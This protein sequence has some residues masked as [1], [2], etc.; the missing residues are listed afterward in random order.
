[1]YKLPYSI[2]PDKREKSGT[3]IYFKGGKKLSLFNN[4]SCCGNNTAGTTQTKTK[5]G[6]CVCELLNQLA[7]ARN[8]GDFCTLAQTMAQPQAF[9]IIVKGSNEP[10]GVSPGQPDE[11]TLLSFDPE[12]CCA[13]FA[14]VPQGMQ[15]P[16]TV[17]L[18]CRCICGL[19]CVPPSN[20]GGTPSGKGLGL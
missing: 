5:C 1:L 16:Q 7:N 3:C 17:V 2:L 10:L 19:V 13:I 14:T 20:G 11:F 4:G 18:D 8:N 15:T 9:L 12:T 6:G